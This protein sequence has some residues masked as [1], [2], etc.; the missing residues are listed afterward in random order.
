MPRFAFIDVLLMFLRRGVS[1]WIDSQHS[2][3]WQHMT[4]KCNYVSF[5]AIPVNLKMKAEFLLAEKHGFIHKYF[6]Q[7]WLYPSVDQAW[8]S[9]N[10]A[11]VPL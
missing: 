6:P 10:I 1:G 3:L 9:L 11:M 2:P 7:H 4:Q 8:F 5:S